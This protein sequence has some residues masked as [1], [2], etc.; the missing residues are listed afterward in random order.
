MQDTM[1]RMNPEPEPQSQGH[2]QIQSPHPYPSPQVEGPN[3]AYAR[4][5]SAN[6]AGGLSEMTG[7][8]QYAYQ[9]W[10]LFERCPHSARTLEQIARVEMQHLRLMG[11]TVVL[12]GGDPRFW[13]LGRNCNPIWWNG[14]YVCHTHSMQKMMLENAAMEQAAIDEYEKQ[15]LL[16][17]DPNIV[18]LL[19]RI[20]EDERLHLSLFR[21]FVS[22]AQQ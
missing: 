2:R 10:V 9:S 14:S 7:A 18:A 17:G 4:M 6:M 3:P 15:K 8:C 5:L 20:L 1:H 12:L 21:R 16:I 13:Q 22:E 11:Q 19:E